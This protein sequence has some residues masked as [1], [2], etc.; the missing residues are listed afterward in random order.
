MLFFT[1]LY[2]GWC[3]VGSGQPVK[4]CATSLQASLLAGGEKAPRAP[5]L[6]S[7]IGELV[8]VRSRFAA[9]PADAAVWAVA[10]RAAAAPARG[11]GADAGAEEECALLAE[12]TV[13]ARPDGGLCD[14]ALRLTNVSASDM[15]CFY[16]PV[17]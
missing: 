3:H 1:C 7:S 16:M 14:G 17:Q 4:K 8:S 9:Q 5:L 10:E 13:A 6:L 11:S 2:S 12:C 15:C